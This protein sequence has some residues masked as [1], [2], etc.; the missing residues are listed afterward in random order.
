MFIGENSLVDRVRNDIDAVRRTVMA[1]SCSA[2][3]ICELVE[4]SDVIF[5]GEVI[6]D[7]LDP[8]EN[9]WSGRPRSA[10]L[11]IIESYKGLPSDIR[12]VTVALQYLPGMCSPAVYR[13][14]EQTLAFLSRSA[15]DST[16][17][18]GACSGSR[19]AKDAI[20]ELEYVRAYFAGRTQTTIRGKVAANTSSGLVSF[21]LRSP[22]GTPGGAAQ[23]IAE[24]NGRTFSGSTNDR[25]EYSLVGIPPGN[26]KVRAEKRGFSRT[27]SDDSEP[28]SFSV[29]VK[30]RGCAIQD[31]GLWTRNSVEGAVRDATGQPVAGIH[32]F[33]QK[34]NGERDRYG[35]QATTNK[36]GQFKFE[37][38]DPRPHYL[39]VSPFGATADSPFEPRFYGGANLRE[40]AKPLNIDGFSVLRSHDIEL[41]N[42]ITTRSIRIQLQWNDG[43]PVSNAFVRCGDA[44]MTNEQHFGSA[45]NRNGF[46]CD[47]LTDR[48]FRIRVTRLETRMDLLDTPAIVVPAGD[49]EVTVT[50]RVG[51][52]DTAA[53]RR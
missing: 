9:A 44:R 4:N 21:V 20:D 26:Y 45:K 51:P 36:N 49:D 47:A 50:I 5:L 10:T 2:V 8:G 24:G 53:S 28:T 37:R 17:R 3:N 27:G 32:I 7:G 11:R 40:Q 16:L 33:L 15:G 46:V 41:G 52:Q 1:C 6:R 19:F 25:G 38:I 31:L 14:G 35:E 48:P 13:R 39:V 12:E 22:E 30:G 23:V 18:D 43:E 29:N 34:V 42:R